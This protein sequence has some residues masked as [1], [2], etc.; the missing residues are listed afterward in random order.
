[1]S[2][3]DDHNDRCER[4]RR[5]NT[6]LDKCAS[7][8]VKKF[9]GTAETCPRWGRLCGQSNALS[10]SASCAIVLVETLFHSRGNFVL[11]TCLPSSKFVVFGRE[12]VAAN[13]IAPAWKFETPDTAKSLA[14]SPDVELVTTAGRRRWM[15]YSLPS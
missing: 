10:C 2:R 14:R 9:D 13:Q 12:T 3:A 1:M 6:T 15:K 7:I 11:P 4:S 5:S 8:L